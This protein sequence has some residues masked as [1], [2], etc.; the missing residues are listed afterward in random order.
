[1]KIKALLC[2]LFSSSLLVA[3][4]SA[5]C[6][7][8]SPPGVRLHIKALL[9]GPLVKMATNES[10][11]RDDLRAKGYLPNTEPYSNTPKFIHVGNDGGGETVTNTD[12]FNTVGDNAIVDWVFIE[13][14]SQAD[15][16]V[17]LATRS[18]LLQRDGDVVDV[19]GVSPVYFPSAPKGSYHVAV[20]H[21][22]H[23]GAMSAQALALDYAPATVDFTDPGFSVYGD[24]ATVEIDG[25]MAL[26]GGDANHDDRVIFQGP[27]N[28]IFSIF[29]QALSDAGNTSYIANYVVSGYQDTDVNLDGWVSIAGV[30]N[31]KSLLFKMM[32][33]D[34]R[35]L[36]APGVV[37]APNIVFKEQ[38]P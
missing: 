37:Y 23:L 2:L 34:F 26:K 10:L 16:A 5:N 6:P 9:Q 31:D 4:L 32:Y 11:M 1:M 28:D 7:L 14:R 29:S 3:H 20:K 17:V 24:H 36:D 15:P 19:D 8:A 18:A 12:V 38:L 33:Q 13:L 25:R 21:R 22:N 27:A 30:E 35:S